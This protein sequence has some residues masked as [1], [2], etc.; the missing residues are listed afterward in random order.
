MTLNAIKDCGLDDVLPFIEELL[1]LGLVYWCTIVL[2]STLGWIQGK[3]GKRLPQ[4][5]ERILSP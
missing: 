2:L 4:V 1:A 5:A 3:F